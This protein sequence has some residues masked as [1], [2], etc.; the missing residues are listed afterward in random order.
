MLR[1]R[2]FGVAAQ[3][4]SHVD[5][6]DRLQ[7]RLMS[8]NARPRS[9][10]AGRWID[11]AVRHRARRPR[12]AGRVDHG[13]S[14]RGRTA[15]QSAAG[16][17]AGVHGA[18]QTPRRR[19]RGWSPEPAGCSVR[20][21]P[22]AGRRGR[23]GTGGLGGRGPARRRRRGCRR[24]CSRRWTP[25]GRHRRRPPGADTRI[26]RDRHRTRSSGRRPAGLRRTCIPPAAGTA[27]PRS[28]P[29]SPSRTRTPPA[30][31]CGRI[32]RACWPAAAP[33]CWWTTS[34]PPAGPL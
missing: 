34:C 26:R 5:I 23:P 13:R 32:R 20:W 11:R 4:I 29:S 15:T 2:A 19:S 3:G 10:M 31:C 25:R 22:G 12:F 30:T 6:M 27:R 8:S 17:A 7:D 18:G 28:R 24:P 9:A 33:S 14:H 1:A 21:W 16:A